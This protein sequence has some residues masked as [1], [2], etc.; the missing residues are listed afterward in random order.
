MLHKA[1]SSTNLASRYYMLTLFE[2]TVNCSVWYSN[3]GHSVL[4]FLFRFRGGTQSLLIGDSAPPPGPATAIGPARFLLLNWNHPRGN[5]VKMGLLS[6]ALHFNK[7]NDSMGLLTNVGP[8]TYLYIW[9][10]LL[11]CSSLY[12][13]E[14]S[15][16]LYI[17]SASLSLALLGIFL[18]RS[19]HDSPGSGSCSKSAKDTSNWATLTYIRNMV[20]L[21]PQ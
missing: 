9:G 12:L 16:I 18:G 13:P 10:V 7:E 11:M 20:G 19:W 3:N 8:F 15:F 21:S 2:T 5:M 1:Q 6:L 14:L 17:F 4:L